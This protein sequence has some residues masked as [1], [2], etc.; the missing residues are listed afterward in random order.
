MAQPECLTKAP[1]RG[2]AGE[3]VCARYLDALRQRNHAVW[4]Q[5]ANWFLGFYFGVGDTRL[6]VPARG[7]GGLPDPVRRVLNFQ[8]PLGRKA[9]GVL[10]LA[11]V[12]FGL[13]ALFVAA[14]LL[15]AR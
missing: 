5:R 6:W 2:P 12:S 10:T 8:H 4:S 3:R 11:Y 14:H 1:A 7:R 13:L 15:G 9:F